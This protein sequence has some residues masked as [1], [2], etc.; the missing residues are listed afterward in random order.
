MPEVTIPPEITPEN[1][2]THIVDTSSKPEYKDQLTTELR[3]ANVI[4]IVYAIDDRSSF[5]SIHERWL[6]M[7]RSNGISVPVILIG[8]KVDTRDT[9]NMA[10]CVLEEEVK[11]I[12]SEYKEIE[13]CIECSAK[14]LLNVS[15]VFYFAQKAVLHPLR[16]L[17]DSQTHQLRPLCASALKRI[18]RLCDHDG[19]GVLNNKELNDFQHACFNAP[20]Q[21]QELESVKAIVSKN[22]PEGV[23]SHGLTVEGFLYLHWTFIQ[24]GRFE[25]TWM[26][27]RKFGYGDDLSLREDF[28]H[29]SLEVPHDHCVELSSDGY[30]FLTELFQRYDIDNDA[31]LN[32]YELE[33]LFQVTPGIP[34]KNN[35]FLQSA[36]TNA[37]GYITLQGWLAQWSM[38]TI[39]DH[40][41]TLSYLAYLGY[42]GDTREGI[43][44]VL[45]K[46]N[47]GRKRKKGR[48]QRNVFRCYVF[49]A[50][51]SGKTSFIR[52]FV[53]KDFV[54]TYTPTDRTWT[55]V[56]SAEAKGSERYL[57]LE[58]FGPYDTSVLQ[59]RQKMAECD[60]LCLLY[61]SSDPNS[62]SYI[63]QLRK[64]YS[65]DHI[66]QIFVATKSDVDYAEQRSDLPP[67]VYCRELKVQAPIYISVKEGQLADIFSRITGIIRNPANAT[68]AL[69]LSKPRTATI[70]RYLLYTAIAGASL[71]ALYATYRGI[72]YLWGEGGRL[73]ST[74]VSSR[75]GEL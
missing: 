68:P 24:R 25:T 5:Y 28:L 67:D 73:P 9:S 59:N 22:K 44:V 40:K 17:Y 42:P 62:F 74:G 69:L 32:T 65:L 8:N 20:L 19:D 50:P 6:P 30:S 52:A 70:T 34:W 57:V 29:P 49:G 64:N 14:E 37:S 60:L 53:R 51:K 15:E 48:A 35:S 18:F 31:A 7:L 45:R 33:E 71:T 61:D 66:P 47:P 41:L 11:P 21:Q 58:E 1:V 72:R 13:T 27:L 16:P 3:K 38:T 56:N 4:C 36:V 43:K 26:V 55:A 75:H 2:T 23:T 12:M 63:T 46:A 10:N 39:L 54:P